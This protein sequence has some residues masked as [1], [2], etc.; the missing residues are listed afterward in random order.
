MSDTTMTAKEISETWLTFVND[1]F[2]IENGCGRPDVEAEIKRLEGCN[3]LELI[4]ERHRFATDMFITEALDC[5][6]EKR[7]EMFSITDCGSLAL[8]QDRIQCGTQL[9]IGFVQQGVQIKIE[10]EEALKEFLHQ[11]ILQKP[12]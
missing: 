9:L 5:T 11:L 6:P 12:V 8:V 10:G 2:M 3:Q 7:S 4:R 1:T